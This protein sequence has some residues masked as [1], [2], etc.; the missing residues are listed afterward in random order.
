M[1]NDVYVINA[2]AKG[3][4]T[5]VLAKRFKDWS[6]F[7]WFPLTLWSFGARSFAVSGQ[8]RLAKECAISEFLRSEGFNVP[9]ILH[10]SNAER[11]IFMEYIDGEN[12]SQAIKRISTATPQDTIEAELAQLGKA[13][14]II[15]KVHSHN[16]ALGDTKPE[17]M[18][19]KQDGTIYMID[20]E[21]ATQDATAIKPG[22]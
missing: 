15:A 16:I 4:E 11:L 7:K 9:K 13:G 20:F 10:V 5:K 1:L 22:M 17:N 12:L 21:Q 2:H 19:V 3:S 8:A 6:G 14:E 18:L